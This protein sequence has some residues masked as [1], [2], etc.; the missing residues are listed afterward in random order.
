MNRILREADEELLSHAESVPDPEVTVSTPEDLSGRFALQF[1]S[2]S[3]R[4]LALRFV[5][6]FQSQLPD[7]RI[8][9]TQDEHGQFLYNIRTG[10]FVNPALARTEAARLRRAHSIDVQVTDLSDGAPLSE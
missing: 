7:I 10:S 9:Q 2:F 8:D 1:G 5:Q 3:D 4:S 6:R